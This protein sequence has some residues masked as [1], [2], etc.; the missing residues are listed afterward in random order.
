M[1][2]AILERLRSAM[3]SG[4]INH[5]T[6]DDTHSTYRDRRPVTPTFRSLKHRAPAHIASMRQI[7]PG[8]TAIGRAPC[9]KMPAQATGSHPS[10]MK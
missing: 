1:R 5:F 3:T 8:M 7:K 6:L 4:K 9:N 10:V 2:A